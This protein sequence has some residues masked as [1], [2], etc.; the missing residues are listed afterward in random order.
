MPGWTCTAIALLIIFIG[1][2]GNWLCLCVFARK[3][4]RTSILTPFFVALLIADCIYLLCRVMKVFYYRQTLF[5]EFLS[6]TSC[7]S[8]ILTDFY[9]Y[10]T[11]TAPQIF[12][13]FAHYEFYIRFSLL[14]M[15][16]LAVQRAYDM[17]GSSNRFLS[18]KS[19]SKCLSYLLII[20]ALIL[21]YLFEL[22]GL[23]IFC[24]TEL[25]E[26]LA[27]QWYNTLNQNLT[28]ETALF[29]A[30]MKNQSA[31]TS[32]IN[33]LMMNPSSCSHEQVA[34]IVRKHQRPSISFF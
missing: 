14:L 34:H 7:M 30:F 23:S 18:R 21:S 13:P 3:R 8:S 12:V 26:H 32:E 22:F 6:S 17:C 33:C 10:F 28:N 24:S 16:F 29:L 19:N 27:Y 4:F 1:S 2:V 15:C 5:Q 25:S 11:Q 20:S 31:N 9:G